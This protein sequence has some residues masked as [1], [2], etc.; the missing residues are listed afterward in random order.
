MNWN[1]VSNDKEAKELLRLFGGFHDACIKEAHL[2]TGHRVDSSLSMSCTGEMDTSMKFLVQ[3]QFENP[4]CI[5]LL[6]EGITRFNFV[7]SPEGAN[8]VIYES[9]LGENEG[10]FF[11]V[12][13]TDQTLDVM[14]AIEDSWVTS[15]KLSWRAADDLLGRDL[16]YG[17]GT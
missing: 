8:S 14:N 4:S 11:W 5:E 12:V 1:T 10:L 3:R 13:D 2:W 15:Q 7:P 17:S 16:Q 9:N 6:F